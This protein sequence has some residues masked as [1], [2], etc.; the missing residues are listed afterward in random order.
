MKSLSVGNL[1]E[2]TGGRLVG[3]DAEVKRSV[4]QVDT[5]SRKARGGSLFIPLIGE[6]FDAHAFIEDALE[7]GAEGW[8]D[9]SGAETC[10]GEILHS[11]GGYHAR[12]GRAGEV[13]QK[14]LAV[15][16]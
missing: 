11:G 14:P 12:P 5:D 9:G 8:P 16:W 3:G 15:P 1:L 10:G 6:R 13:V 4:T 2:A 7:Q